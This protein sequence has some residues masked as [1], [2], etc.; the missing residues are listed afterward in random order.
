MLHVFYIL[1][2][3]NKEEGFLEEQFLEHLRRKIVL[4]LKYSILFKHQ[5]YIF[6]IF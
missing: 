4:S 5:I 2:Y 1:K 6:F 3:R